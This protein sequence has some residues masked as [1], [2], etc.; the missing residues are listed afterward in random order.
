M[1]TWFEDLWE[2]NYEFFN[3]A[4]LNAATPES[5]LDKLA[6]ELA[7]LRDDHS[8]EEGAD[9]AVCLIGFFIKSGYECWQFL[10]ALEAKTDVN[11]ARTWKLQPE[12]FYKHD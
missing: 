6:E 2:K 1:S 10:E 7:E 11:L 12:G 3:Q 8:I 9:V 4:A 5:Q